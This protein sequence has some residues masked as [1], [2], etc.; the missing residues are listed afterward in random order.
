MEDSKIKTTSSHEDEILEQQDQGTKKKLVH[1]GI[2]TDLVSAELKD[3][4]SSAVE[5]DGMR[6]HDESPLYTPSP[7]SL[8]GST[9]SPPSIL[10][11]PSQRLVKPTYDAPT[12]ASR[13]KKTGK[14]ELPAP[15]KRRLSGKDRLSR[16]GTGHGQS[17]SDLSSSSPYPL[18]GPTSAPFSRPSSAAPYTPPAYAHGGDTYTDDVSELDTIEE[19]PMKGEIEIHYESLLAEI[20]HLRNDL[21]EAEKE[22]K[23]MRKTISEAEEDG[24]ELGKEVVALRATKGDIEKQENLIDTLQNQLKKVNEEKEETK[25]EL[26]IARNDLERLM[27]EFDIKRQELDNAKGSMEDLSQERYQLS[28]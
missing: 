1:L 3:W 22:N 26:N 2:D 7:R 24:T 27:K 18:S 6:R 4:V 21:L 16:P 25:E 14:V 19:Q 9:H 23:E 12:K 10:R 13:A 17:P 11:H 20:T 15:V 8:T 28:T 5:R